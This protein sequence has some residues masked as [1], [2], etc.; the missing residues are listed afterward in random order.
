MFQVE[1]KDSPRPGKY[2]VAC[3]DA[4]KQ[5][6]GRVLDRAIGQIMV[7]R[8]HYGP[9]EATWKLED[10]M[11]LAHPFCSNLQSIEGGANVAFC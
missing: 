6:L 7:Q 11:Q 8:K 4:C 3:A 10:A 9:K 2:L 1:E 5:G